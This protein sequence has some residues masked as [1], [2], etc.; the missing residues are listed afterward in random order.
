MVGHYA[1]LFNNN[2]SNNNKNNNNNNN[3]PNS[4][5]K[6][7]NAQQSQE[8]SNAN[9][10]NNNMPSSSTSST[11]P[12]SS[13]SQSAASAAA[14]L[15]QQLTPEAVA[16]LPPPGL[17]GPSNI[18]FSPSNCPT[19]YMAFLSSSSQHHHHSQQQQQ[20]QQRSRSSI[21]TPSTTTDRQLCVMDLS[22]NNSHNNTNYFPLLS[23][24][25]QLNPSAL[26][27]SARSN[28]HAQPY[29]VT[30]MNHNNNNHHT[31][32]LYSSRQQQQ[33]TTTATTTSHH[34]S[35]NNNNNSMMITHYSW[36]Y[37]PSLQNLMIL[38]PLRGSL[39]LQ[40]GLSSSTNT[41]ATTN[42]PTTTT[43]C[44]YAKPK[45]GPPA[46]DAQLSP[47][48]QWVAF[49]LEGD[50]YVVSTSS[51]QNLLL[52]L[53][54][55]SSPTLSYGLADNFVAQEE[56]DR[57]EGYWWHPDSSGLVLTEVDESEVPP[58]RIHHPEG[59]GYE[60]HRY[61]FCGQTNPKTQ[62]GFLPLTDNAVLSQQILNGSRSMT[63]S[64]GT[65]SS[66]TV[67]RSHAHSQAHTMNV[68]KHTMSTNSHTT[69][70]TMNHSTNLN[71]NNNNLQSNTSYS[72][73][74]N[75]IHWFTPPRE[76]KEYLARVT[77]LPDGSA[78]AQWQNRTQTCLVYQR[79]EIIR[80]ANA[81][82]NCNYKCKTLWI[83]RRPQGWINLTH[84][85]QVV[86]EP[87]V[88]PTVNTQSSG[89]LPDGSF[90][91]IL[92]SEKTDFM[93]LY[94]YT[95][96]P[97]WNNDMLIPV[98]AL[99]E[100]EWMVERI[101]GMDAKNNVLY[102]MG[103]YDSV[104]EKH[105][106]AIPI[107]TTAA[108]TTGGRQLHRKV[109]SS[110]NTTTNMMNQH[111]NNH[112]SSSHM[113]DVEYDEQQ[114]QQQI[115]PMRRSLKNVMSALSG[116]NNHAN[117]SASASSSTRQSSSSQRRN[118]NNT[119]TT[120][121]HAPIRLTPLSGMHNVVMDSD[122][123]YFVDTSSDLHRPTTVQIYQVL[124]EQF[125]WNNSHTNCN[126]N[127]NNNNVRRKASA[128]NN[129]NT[130]T[131]NGKQQNPYIRF[132]HTLY[133]A[134][135]DDKT[136]VNCFTGTTGTSRSTTTSTGTYNASSSNPISIPRNA[137]LRANAGA[138]VF[139]PPE[140]RSFPTTDGTEILHAALY[141][142]DPAI[143]GNGPY[144]LVC[145]V[146]GGPHVQRVCRSWSQTCDLR[147]QRLRSIGFLVVKCDNRGSARRG[148]A[149]ESSIQH[150]LGRLEVLDQVACV[151]YLQKEGLALPSRHQKAGVYGWSYGGYLALQCLCRAPNVFGCGVAGAPVTSWDGYD[152][153]YTERYMGLPN[154]AAGSG[155]TTAAYTEASVLEHVPLLA[156]HSKLLLLHG[157][158]DENVH[159]RHTTRLIS[160]LIQYGKEY[161]LILFPEE[162]H[163]PRRLRDRIYMEQKLSDFLVQ[164]LLLLN[165]NNNNAGQQQQQH[166]GL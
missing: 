96:C 2:N 11:S 85:M 112:S 54:Y 134:S 42:T 32:N 102:V 129:N 13:S 34:S 118:N 87:V 140:L 28:N 48:G 158:M 26:S 50:L 64:T 71:N 126:N 160:R 30:A 75:F 137:S 131:N 67:T 106:Y 45:G 151:E 21:S 97:G 101:V 35:N 139:Q 100:G 19:T 133:D 117:T 145:S 163:S 89:L 49:V 92:A 164:H 56:M 95:Y 70:P 105:L 57:H 6:R 60:D 59:G 153:H 20:Q 141:Q 63:A 80:N 55:K 8:R 43:T 113:M 1:T 146:Y 61:P 127:N 136:I 7:L 103:T 135:V 31:V 107:N 111:H 10:N 161:E 9:N 142:P 122:G 77:W 40:I 3:N 24:P 25:L 58:Y 123:K 120:T 84:M 27:Q 94:L 72:S 115:N 109:T 23:S 12:Y 22:H 144:P 110:N 93:H 65:T 68:N 18:M 149:F 76:A 156:N 78:C 125:P 14:Q 150:R 17:T 98:R 130:N 166:A 52:R 39:Y 82:A 47:N 46:M 108:A 33:Q 81:A 152:T 104:L 124:P 88:P 4:S 114:Q 132:L 91:L 79:I 159:F 15:P 5:N 157:L 154:N 90:S 41:T 62:L 128:S 66:P 29:N 53:T 16:A 36:V 148:W 119:N 147:A 51:S 86:N 121:T 138:S 165:N 116:G 99:T 44:L 162:R 38:L 155:S 37:V 69:S 83:E 74:N 73:S 143:F